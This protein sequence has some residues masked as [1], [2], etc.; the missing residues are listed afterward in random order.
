MREV[1]VNLISDTVEE[2]C[3]EA[4][5]RLSEDIEGK[6]RERQKDEENPIAK[7]I[8]SDMVKNLEIADEKNMPICQ[9]TGMAVLFIEVG[10]DVHFSGNITEAVNEGVR[11]GYKNGY[12]RN[13]VVGDP[14]LRK[15]TGDNTPAVI[16]YDIV[17]G[18]RVNIK[19]AAKGFGS[20]NMGRLGMLKPSD[21]IEGV[22]SFILETVK[23]AGPNPCPPVVVGVGIGGT[24]D[25]ACQLAKKALMRDINTFNEKE[26]IRELE[27][28]MLEKINELGI[29][30]QG[31]GGETTAL[32][33]NIETYPTHIAGL[34]IAV[35]INCHVA[36]HIERTV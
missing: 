32:G 9:D 2:M 29:G 8:L 33:I 36:R 28:E 22:K 27:E 15:N 24:M 12:L 34:P 13:S 19:F 3:M 26:H 25:K 1:D 11:R 14:L 5:Y 4:N 35:N 31:L 18:D 20:E 16:Y 21:G 17:E 7:D 23:I 6:I 10:R 30:P